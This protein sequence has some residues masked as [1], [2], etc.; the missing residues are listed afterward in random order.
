LSSGGGGAFTLDHS[1]MIVSADEPAVFGDGNG[2]ADT[3]IDYAE[4]A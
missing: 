1:S 4:L 3:W 2:E